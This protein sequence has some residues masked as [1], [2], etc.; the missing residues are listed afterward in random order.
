MMKMSSEG[1]SGRFK[2]GQV[3]YKTMAQS[4]LLKKRLNRETLI[5]GQ[6]TIKGGCSK[7]L[8]RFKLK[9]KT[10]NFVIPMSN[11]LDAVMTKKTKVHKY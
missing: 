7:S 6:T 4:D 8:E 2:I 3:N 11:R 10:S 1:K 9:D 5:K